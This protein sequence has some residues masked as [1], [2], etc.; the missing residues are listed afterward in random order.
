MSDF[1]LKQVTM[2]GIGFDGGGVF[3]LEDIGAVR[4]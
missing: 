4:G 1:V 3:L 2:S